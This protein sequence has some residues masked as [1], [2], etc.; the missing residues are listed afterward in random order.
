MGTPQAIQEDVRWPAAHADALG[1]A[2]LRLAD[3]LGNQAGARQSA[4][5]R[6]Q[7]EFRGNKSTDFA[8][9]LDVNRRNAEALITNLQALRAALAAAAQ[10]AADEQA[11][12]ERARREEDD[13]RWFGLKGVIYDIAD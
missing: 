6:A 1:A 13:R 2:S 12:R 9:R 11:A 5:G 4:A 10:W 3:L 8:S 7:E